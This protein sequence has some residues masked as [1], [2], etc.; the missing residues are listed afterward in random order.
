MFDRMMKQAL[1]DPHFLLDEAFIHASAVM[2]H[3]M[4]PEHML[5][6]VFAQLQKAMT[7][8]R[9]LIKL[10]KSLKNQK[11]EIG[12]VISG[13]LQLNGSADKS[14]YAFALSRP[15]APVML[16]IVDQFPGDEPVLKF[17]LA[18]LPE[19]PPYLCLFEPDTRLFIA[20][21]P[22]GCQPPTRA[23]IFDAVSV[24]PLA[25]DRPLAEIEV[26]DAAEGRNHTVLAPNSLTQDV[27][28][29]LDQGESISLRVEYGMA[30]AIHIADDASS[31][32]F[33]DTISPEGS[34]IK[35]LVLPVSL[36]REWLVDAIRIAKLQK[37]RVLC[38]GPTGG[39]KTTCVERIGRDAFSIREKETGQPCPGIRLI[40]ISSQDIG[41]SYIHATERR[42]KQA[43]RKAKHLIETGYICI[44]LLDEGDQMLGQM[45]GGMEH[46]H[47]HSERLA[48]QAI[49]SENPQVPVYV[50]CNRRENAFIAA[51]LQ[52][53]FKTRE[54]GRP[55][56]SQLEYVCRLY[57]QGYPSVL[58]KLSLSAAEFAGTFA[59]NLFSDSRVVAQYHLYSGAQLPVYARDLR[60]CSCGKIEDI[61]NS[62]AFELKENLAGSSLE[63]LWQMLDQEFSGAHLNIKNTVELTYLRPP[64]DD[65]IRSVELV[66]TTAR[67][68]KHLV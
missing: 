26:K 10:I 40:R 31:S 16:R 35:D 67:I 14:V 33:T 12:M 44:V 57:I 38:V 11:L 25:E 46:A 50:T 30:R 43:F 24:P 29:H 36:Q 63:H 2:V 58:D 47:N 15:S 62:Y 55:N 56:R 45:S 23:E 22:E 60:I 59:D 3:E 54:Y 37:V 61:V 51:P 52:R 19:E 65:A 13:I 7:Q 8:N 6:T 28:H 21:V 9:E 39:G 32:D 68:Q 20:L 66:D 18:D 17:K 27:R 49:L 48:L 53:R 5:K 42:L 4:G 1:A 64:A 41:S 34:L